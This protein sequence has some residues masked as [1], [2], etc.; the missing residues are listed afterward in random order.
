MKDFSRTIEVHDILKEEELKP[1]DVE[2]IF[3][4]VA[5]VNWKVKRLKD[6]GATWKNLNSSLLKSLIDEYNSYT[7]NLK[8]GKIISTEK[9][10][11]DEEE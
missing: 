11:K 3:N 7:V 9:I 5:S 8:T 4:E 10:Q 1:K 2:F 6:M